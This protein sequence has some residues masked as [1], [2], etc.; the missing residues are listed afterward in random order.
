MRRLFAA[1]QKGAFPVAYQL[2]C[3][4]Q[5]GAPRSTFVTLTVRNSNRY[6]VLGQF[7]KPLATREG[8]GVCTL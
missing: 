2:C 1:M 8:T 7:E 4:E 5:W 3:I 6:F